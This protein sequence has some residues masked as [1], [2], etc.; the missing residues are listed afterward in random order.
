M[1]KYYQLTVLSL[2]TVFSLVLFNSCGEETVETGYFYGIDSF[3]EQPASGD[4]LTVINNYLE[5]VGCRITKGNQLMIFESATEA[6]NNQKAINIF[7]LNVE[8]IDEAE[9]SRKMAGLNAKFIYVLVGE[10]SVPGEENVLAK[11]EY[12]FGSYVAE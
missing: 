6:E 3:E 4:A 8:K 2:I 9:F 10:S 11:K 7:N 5:A 12:K 1:K